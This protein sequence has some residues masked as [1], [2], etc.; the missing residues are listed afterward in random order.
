MSRSLGIPVKLLHEAAG[1][2]VT[3]ELKSGELYRGSM[4]ECED[5]WNCHSKKSPSLLRVKRFPNLSMPLSV[6]AKSGTG[7]D[8]LAFGVSISKVHCSVTNSVGAPECP[9]DS[10]FEKSASPFFDDLIPSSA[11]AAASSIGFGKF[12]GQNIK[13]ANPFRLLQDYASDDSTENGNVPCA[14]DAIPVTVSPSVTADTGLHRD[15]KYNLDSGLR[16]ERTCRTERSFEPSSEPES[17]VDD[18]H[19]KKSASGGVDIVP[20][21]G[22]SQKEMPP[23][24]I[25]EFGRLVKE[26]ASDSVS[27]DS[28][29]A[30]K[31]GK[32][33]SCG[34]TTAQVLEM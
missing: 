16:S 34:D 17:P 29:Y 7:H 3:V 19:E 5:N 10:G 20:E 18:G 24:K 14:E 32:S 2:V 12:P 6:V 26:G 4:I 15:I 30:R 8:Y 11:S 31:H 28:C 27:D 9:L 25:D 1:H 23:L 22:K 13:G 33:G 21:S